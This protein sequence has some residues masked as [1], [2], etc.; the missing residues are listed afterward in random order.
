MEDEEAADASPASATGSES[1][2]E[3]REEAGAADGVSPALPDA[4]CVYQAGGHS[5]W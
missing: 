1:G 4:F 5:R 2:E 3:V